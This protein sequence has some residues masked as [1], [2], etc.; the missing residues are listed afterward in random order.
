MTMD[1]SHHIVESGMRFPAKILLFGEYNLVMGQRGFLIPFFPFSGFF[2]FENQNHN[3]ATTSNKALFDFA[4]FLTA[5]HSLYSF[6]DVDRFLN[7][8]AQGIWFNSSVP[9]GSGLGSSG[10]LVAAVYQRYGVQISTQ[11]SEVKQHLA[12][13]ERFFHGQSSGADP[14]TA[15]LQKSIL[16]SENKDVIVLD[17]WKADFGDI[18]IFLVH[19]GIF[20]KTDGL[21]SWF[22]EQYQLNTDFHQRIDHT[23][24]PLSNQLATDAA[25]SPSKIDFEKIVELSEFQLN[26]FLPMIPE[27]FKKHICYGINTNAFALKLCGSG[28]GGY[29]LGFT[30]NFAKAETYFKKNGIEILPILQ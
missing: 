4:S 22:L 15:Y 9:Q 5:N 30:T 28:G 18:T 25:L 21:V 16:L 26:H 11:L 14:L 19:T 6:L 1:N 17:D 2:T 20:S 29:L 10:A 27:M 13:I 3:L 8:V 7:E 23:Y 24:L 12:S